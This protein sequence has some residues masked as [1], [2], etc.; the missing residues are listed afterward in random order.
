M[1]LEMI[2]FPE[3]GFAQFRDLEA[4]HQFFKV[5]QKAFSEG[6]NMKHALRRTKLL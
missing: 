1:P 5:L 4:L 3:R 6:R 2:W